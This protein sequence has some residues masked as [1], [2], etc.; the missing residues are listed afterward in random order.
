MIHENNRTVQWNQ[1]Y[2][3]NTGFA[4]DETLLPTGLE[5]K[6]DLTGRDPSKW[7][8]IGWYYGGQFWP[9]TEAFMAAANSPGFKSLGAAMDGSFG[10]TDPQGT[11]LPHDDLYPPTSLQPQGTRYAIDMEQRYVEWSK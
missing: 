7:S 3:I 1:F 9:T 5:F 11:Q 2:A 4:I 8:V 10:S 6:T